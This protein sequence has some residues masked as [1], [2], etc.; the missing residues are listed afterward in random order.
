VEGSNGDAVEPNGVSESQNALIHLHK[1]AGAFG[2]LDP[3]DAPGFNPVSTKAAL[4]TVANSSFE[5]VRESARL[6]I[7]HDLIQAN[8]GIQKEA[9]SELNEVANSVADR[10]GLDAATLLGDITTSAVEKKPLSSTKSGQELKP[11]LT[12]F[13][14]QD[15]CQIGKVEVDGIDATWIFSELETDAPFDNVAQWVDPRNWVKRGPLLFKKMEPVGSQQP[16]PIK[17][18]SDDHWHAVFHEEVQLVKELN[19]LLHCDFWRD[20]DR[21]AGM[22]YELDH[23]I[24]K[25]INVDRGFLLVNEA[26]GVRR[27]KAL[28]IVGFTD[29]M[30][31]WVATFVCPFWTDFVRAAVEDGSNNVPG[32]ASGQPADGSP[33]DLAGDLFAA[34]MEFLGESGKAYLDLF[35]DTF[36]RVTSGGYSASDWVED[37]TRTWSQLAKDWARAW[38]YGLELV[39]D[40][41]D[42]GLD[43]S[44]MPPDTT[45]EERRRGQGLATS[46]R[47]T[48]SSAAANSTVIPIPGLPDGV[49]PTCSDLTSIEENGPVVPAGAVGIALEQLADKTPGARISIGA[50]VTPGLYVGSLEATGLKKP[51]PAQIYVSGAR[52]RSGN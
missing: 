41:K 22:T 43:A 21:S 2:D 51:V 50:N 33:T 35:G 11:H 26:D 14:G 48:A 12:A 45:A 8:P 18:L 38:S 44:F 13:I 16:T 4:L 34:W 49:V 47:A 3:A 6:A 30:W 42:E 28:K 5:E 19:T 23:S 40:V 7:L 9:A 17:T 52:R 25:E 15:I 31:D 46:L 37:G 32:P 1:E 39:D 10:H 24:D 27:V 36:S 29:D 20:G